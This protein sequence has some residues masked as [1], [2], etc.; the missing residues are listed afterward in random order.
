MDN[1]KAWFINGMYNILI[2]MNLTTN[3]CELAVRIPE[4]NLN[5]FRLNPFCIKCDKDV[6]CI[7]GIGEYIWIYDSVCKSFSKTEI[8]NPDKLQLSFKFYFWEEKIYA[9]PSGTFNKILEINI[10]E[11]KVDNYYTI[12]ETGTIADSTIAGS[13]IY[14]LDAESNKI[15][16][17][18]LT[19]KSMR[20]HIIPE[21]GKK[22]FTICFDGEKFCISG[23]RKEVY[24]W[25][26][27]TNKLITLDGFSQD[28][29]I[30]NYDENSEEILDCETRIYDVSTFGYSVTAGEYI[31]FIPFQTNKIVYISKK[32]YQLYTFE[33]EEE[34]ET[35]KSLL[36]RICLRIKY[37]LE[38]VKDNRYIGLFSLKNNRILE[39]DAVVLSYRWKNYDF[40]DKCLNLFQKSGQEV[41]HEKVS[42]DRVTYAMMV[43]TGKHSVCSD[44]KEVGTEI[45]KKI[46]Y[47]IWE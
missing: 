12:C 14:I 6:Y 27:E 44:K 11:R 19:D 35:K 45:Y 24:V 8:D 2:C 42:M 18:E 26:K 36:G 34:S 15:Y 40:S 30:Y 39:I 1:D 21:S 38:Y 33:I 32:N 4:A 16:E 47:N 17:F 43:R 13:T 41:W 7:P 37:V 29:G 31:W 3:K 20:L 28:F 25:T 9:V 22:F 10:S 23:Y 46:K 5:T